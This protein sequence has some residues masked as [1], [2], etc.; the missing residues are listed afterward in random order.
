MFLADS[1]LRTSI[2]GGPWDIMRLFMQTTQGNLFAIAEISW[3][4]S[5]IVM[6]FPFPFSFSIKPGILSHL[7]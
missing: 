1:Y 6:T 2:D 4:A 7:L 5:I 3:V